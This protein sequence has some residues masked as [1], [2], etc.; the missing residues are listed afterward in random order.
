MSGNYLY[1]LG[2]KP[3]AETA[4]VLNTLLKDASEEDIVLLGMITILVVV[5]WDTAAVFVRVM[6][7]KNTEGQKISP[8]V[9]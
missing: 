1:Q 8:L 2:G 4:V 5:K 7:L 3:I 9:N 6:N